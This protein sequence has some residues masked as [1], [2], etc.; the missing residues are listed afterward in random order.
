MTDAEMRQL[1]L[2]AM[3]FKRA[4]SPTSAD[5]LL[6]MLGPHRKTPSVAKI[7]DDVL[8]YKFIVGT[9]PTMEAASG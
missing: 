5:A 2:A 1:Q 3:K 4:P 8:D 6:A 7:I 9:I